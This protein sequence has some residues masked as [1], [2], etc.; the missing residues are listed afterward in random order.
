MNLD[1]DIQSLKTCY[2]ILKEGIEYIARH[3]TP[4]HEQIK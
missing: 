2:I 4:F 1:K 3:K